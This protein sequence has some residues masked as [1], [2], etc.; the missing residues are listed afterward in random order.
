MKNFW[1]AL[2]AFA[3][4]VAGCTTPSAEDGGT[5]ANEGVTTLTLSI[6]STRTS[7]GEKVGDTYPVFWSEGDRIAINGIA[8][9]EAL[10]DATN[11]STA[12]F[13]VSSIHD[14]LGSF[15][16]IRFLRNHFWISDI[17]NIRRALIEQNQRNF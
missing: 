16:T 8:S 17:K 12:S 15:A 14:I 11:K 3:L 10:I 13:V 1:F 6:Q 4:S 9:E 5:T 2:V 7:L